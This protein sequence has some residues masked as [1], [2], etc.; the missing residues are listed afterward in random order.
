[1]TPAISILTPT[2]NRANYLERVWT[3]LLA[4]T[5][6]DFEWIVA[7]DGSDDGTAELIATLAR[8]STFPI[9]YLRAAAHVGKA[10]MDNE[11]IARARGELAMWCDSDDVLLPNAVERLLE[12]W[13]SIESSERSNFVGVTALAATA[14]RVIFNP[15]PGEKLIDVSWNELATRF[16]AISDMVYVARRDCLQSHPF[17]EV[18][19]VI[20]ESVVWNVIGHQVARLVPEVLKIV[21]YRAEHAISFSGFMSYNRGRAHALAITVRELEAYRIGWLR[22]LNAL[23]TFLRY[24][25]HGEIGLAEARTLWGSKPNALLFLL[26]VPVA[27]LLATVDL[28][29][30]KVV[31]SHREFLSN[32]DC[33]VSATWFTD[34]VQEKIEIVSPIT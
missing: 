20:P 15:F 14:D 11:A 8:R 7:D 9:L 29:R 31:R 16:P 30:G 1:M 10:R 34:E 5:S 12:V 25:R 3:G 32:R 19:L 22:R 23:V 28:L 26:A 27:S 21:E 18:D 2:W 13:R 17:P 33:A 24:G 4:Q 6:S